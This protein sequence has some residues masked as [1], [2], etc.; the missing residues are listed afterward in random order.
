MGDATRP[1]VN[2]CWACPACLASERED[3]VRS[4]HLSSTSPATYAGCSWVNPR[5]Q[6]RWAGLQELRFYSCSSWLPTR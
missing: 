3:V 5:P 2:G 1:N 6:L 4:L